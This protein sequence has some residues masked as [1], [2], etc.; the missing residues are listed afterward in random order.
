VATTRPSATGV[1]RESL[2][3]ERQ[4]LLRSLADLDA[5]FAAG[6]IEEDDYHSL[7]D[8]YTAR[9]A[10]VLKAIEAVEGPRP[11]SGAQAKAGKSNVVPSHRRPAAPAAGAPRPAGVAKT[12]VT[13]STAAVAGVTRSGRTARAAG[14]GSGRV[15]ESTRA[16]SK[17][18]SRT[19]GG[20]VESEE[21]RQLAAALAG[22]RRWRN[23][24]VVGGVAV[25]ASVAVWAVTAS[26]APRQAG[27]TITG[28]A[29][30]TDTTV[31]NGVDPR[32]V[33]AQ[34]DVTKGDPLDALKEY[35]AVLKDDPTQPVALANQGWLEAQIGLEGNKPGLVTSGLASIA[36]A[37][38]ADPSYA[39][40][41][42]FQGDV[43][44]HENQAPAAV[45]DFRT[46]LGL[47]DP[48]DPNIA[49]AQALLDQAIKAAGPSVP[50]G[51]NAATTTTPAP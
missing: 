23:V 30:I 51:P 19:V 40:P 10:A 21:S 22:R 37:E 3:Q 46:F 9:T 18:V 11:A 34:N 26:T 25:F 50:P 1:D 48:G 43:Q 39:E 38:K 7:T 17:R 15:T 24:A 12:E 45:T 33:D 36:Q 41:W 14:S 13:S 27:Q 16:G 42:F 29:Q 5:E 6:D 8:D 20:A 4:F 35:S 44:L 2:E 28:N 31:P 49:Q 32:L 47:A